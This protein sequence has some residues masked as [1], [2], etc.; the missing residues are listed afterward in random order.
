MQSKI[1]QLNILVHF[2]TINVKEIYDS[3]CLSGTKRDVFSLQ[4]RF[5][6]SVDSFCLL[7]IN[8][9]CKKSLAGML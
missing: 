9:Q 6:L 7:L 3:Q 4:H 8:Y 5:N 2:A 1:L